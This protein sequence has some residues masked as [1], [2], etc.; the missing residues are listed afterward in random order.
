MNNGGTL[1]M[2][3]HNQIHVSTPPGITLAG[4]TLDAGGFSQGTGGT[5]PITDPGTVGLG[6][7]TLSS[8][9]IIDLTSIS[10]LHFS[11]SSAATWAA[12]T[13]S[14]Y[15]WNGTLATG[16]GAEQILFGTSTSG[17]SPTQLAQIQFVN[18]TGF[19]PG[20][21]AA[22]FA[23]DLTGEIVPGVMTPVPEPS[24]WAA[25]ALALARSP[26]PSAGGLSSRWR[27]KVTERPPNNNY[28]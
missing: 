26:G 17:L 13:L 20:T 18:P 9:S 25:A 2:A 24:T 21:Y 22:F 14:I 19:A 12:G 10:V 11:N 15:N 5:N 28:Q 1:L 16:G 4:G 6:A 8:T 23:T 3:A 27:N 7:L